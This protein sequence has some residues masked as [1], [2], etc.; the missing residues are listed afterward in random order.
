MESL[1]LPSLLPRVLK[2][3]HIPRRNAMIDEAMQ[4]P[5]GVGL[6]LKT[7][8]EMYTYGGYSL[9]LGKPGK[10]F[11]S[12]QIKYRD[13]HKGNNPSDMSPTTF[14]D[15]QL[16]PRI[17]TFEE[18]FKQFI[19]I[20]PNYKSLEL[21]GCLIVRN[22]MVLDHVQ[23]VNGNWRYS[24]PVDVITEI[25]SEFPENFGE[26]LEVFLSYIELIALNED[27]KY[28]TLGYDISTGIGRYNNLLT[29][30][31][32]INIILHRRNSSEADF[33]LHLMKFAGGLVRPPAGLNP[34]SLRAAI[35]AFPQLSIQPE[36]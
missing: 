13:G 30:A 16:S 5:R 9:R 22:S 6:D 24:P 25:K 29:Y 19:R 26:P 11:G 7:Y 21:L 20:V 31:N 34:I 10:E 35:Q 4:F 17:G 33:L 15:N 27:T 1:R 18:I 28:R 32:I 12:I 2:Q 23:D 36:N 8:T 14:I 3:I